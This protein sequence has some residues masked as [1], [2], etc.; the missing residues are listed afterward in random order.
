[1]VFLGVNVGII[2]FFKA[3]AVQPY[4]SAP[5]RSPAPA[6]REGAPPAGKG[7]VSPPVKPKHS[8]VV[9]LGPIPIVWGSSS[10]MALLAIIIGIIIAMA[11]LFA[12]LFG[13]FAR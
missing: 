1:M 5:G 2:Y 6:G 3:Y 11:I 8:G 12:V 7:G 13:V 9:F 10:K 4:E